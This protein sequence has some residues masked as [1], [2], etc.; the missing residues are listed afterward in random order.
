[1]DA[2]E[3]LLAEQD[4][5]HL[6]VRA[7]AH[8]DNNEPDAFAALFTDDAVLARPGAEPLQGREA[9]RAAYAKRPADRISR[10]LLAQTLLTFEGPGIAQGRTIVQVW[11]GSTATPDGP[12]GRQAQP[13]LLVGEF[14]DRFVLT[15]QGWRIARREARFVL[16]GDVAPAPGAS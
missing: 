1:M 16:H 3:R 8:A 7:A 6:V 15:P 11:N 4:C 2:L 12:Q 9:I 14:D 10:H 13:R 5:R